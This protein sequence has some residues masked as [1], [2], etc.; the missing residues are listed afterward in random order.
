MGGLADL[1]PEEV[2]NG[3]VA[4]RMISIISWFFYSEFRC[5]IGD[6]L[7]GTTFTFDATDP[8]D[9]IFTLLG[10]CSQPKDG[11]TFSVDYTR[12]VENIYSETARRL[13][14]MDGYADIILYAGFPKQSG[15]IPLPSWVPN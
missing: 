13:V 8:R 1:I 9:K 10:L 3:M 11:T 14:Q 2:R 15:N 12:S 4:C 6:I 7:L 5:F